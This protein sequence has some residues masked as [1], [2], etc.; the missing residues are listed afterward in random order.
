MPHIIKDDLKYNFLNY[1]KSFYK[2]EFTKRLLENGFK[3]YAYGLNEKKDKIT[4]IDIIC[5]YRNI[6]YGMYVDD[7]I[8]INHLILCENKL[9]L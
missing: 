8:L 6:F 3:F 9:S 1:L 2:D 7:G 4:E 5:N